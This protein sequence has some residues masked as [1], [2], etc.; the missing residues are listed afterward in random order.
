MRLLASAFLIVLPGC[1]DEDRPVAKPIAPAEETVAKTNAASL[2]DARETMLENLR[3]LTF[4]G[5]NAEAY[6]SFD[7]TRL[8]FQSTSEGYACDQI[9]TMKIDGSE[10][11]LASTSTGSPSSRRTR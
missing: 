10:R 6:F 9:F 4:G 7:G 11:R 8:V 2:L 5:E 1:A 3:Q